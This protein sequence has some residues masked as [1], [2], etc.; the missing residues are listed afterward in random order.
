MKAK[1]KNEISQPEA[2][3]VGYPMLSYEKIDDPGMGYLVDV[4]FNDI[5]DNNKV[6]CKL[7]NKHVTSRHHE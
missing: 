6:L 1:R 7:C 3:K 5:I 2:G 4:R